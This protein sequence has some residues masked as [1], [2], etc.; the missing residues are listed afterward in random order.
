MEEVDSSKYIVN[1]TCR[2]K[3]KASK[4]AGDKRVVITKASCITTHLSQGQTYSGRVFINLNRLFDK[5]MLYV[6]IS[7]AQ[8]EEDWRPV[9]RPEMGRPAQGP[10]APEERSQSA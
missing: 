9:D 6:A 10:F 8:R 3:D 1:T 2:N 7:R 4:K 5:N